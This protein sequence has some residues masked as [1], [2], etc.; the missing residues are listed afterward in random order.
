M[1]VSRKLTYFLLQK[2]VESARSAFNLGSYFVGPGSSPLI[3]ADQQSLNIAIYSTWRNIKDLGQPA[4]AT[5]ENHSM[6]KIFLGLRIMFSILDFEQFAYARNDF[7]CDSFRD[8]AELIS[9][10]C[11]VSYRSLSSLSFGP[12]SQLQC[13]TQCGPI[14]GGRRAATGP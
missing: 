3:L 6:R 12:N 4:R 5:L 9:P 13:I 11:L 10:E 14:A 1:N 2:T 8:R 7:V